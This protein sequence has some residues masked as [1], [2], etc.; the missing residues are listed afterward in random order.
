MANIWFMMATKGE[1]WLILGG[2]IPMVGWKPLISVGQPPGWRCVVSILKNHLLAIGLPTIKKKT[3]IFFV[4]FLGITIDV[5]PGM[6]S[7]EN[8][9][10]IFYYNNN[11]DEKTEIFRSLILGNQTKYPSHSI[12]ILGAQKRSS[13]DSSI[14]SPSS[15][16]G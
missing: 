7:Q 16:A 10:L 1:S 8:L 3:G 9:G 4:L 6:K 14:Q 2:F 11:W 5:K 12:H 13:Q 15:Q